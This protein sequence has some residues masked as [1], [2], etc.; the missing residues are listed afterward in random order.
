MHELVAG[1]RGVEVIADDFIIFGTTQQ[2][3]DANLHAFLRRAEERNLRLNPD[4][5][6]YKVKSVKWMG[7][8]LSDEGLKADPARIQAIV[9][10]PVPTSASDL[11]RFIGM[12]GYLSRFLPSISEVMT[13]LRQLTQKYVGWYWSEPCQQAFDKVKG[14]LTSAPVL[15]FYDPRREATVQCDASMSGLGACL[16]QD[17]NPVIYCSRALTSAEKAYSQIEKELLSITFALTRL[18]QFL[19]AR[20]VTV[21]TD[22]K[23]LVAIQHKPLGDAPLRLQRMLMTLQRYD[24]TI[25]YKPGS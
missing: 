5:F 3:H 20:P 18:D 16:L 21:I 17:D 22:H 19:Y 6:R 14:L 12:V 2:D 7:H 10:F 8:I 25:V 15:H 11:K 23:P 9:E 1:L 13:P 24:Y 4:K